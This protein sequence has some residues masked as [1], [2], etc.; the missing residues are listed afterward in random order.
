MKFLYWLFLV[1]LVIGG[2]N[3]A[4]IGWF[5]INLVTKIF[6]DVMKTVMTNGVETTTTTLNQLAMITY[7]V[8]GVSALWVFIANLCHKCSK[9]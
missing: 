5:D 8:V 9:K 2:L 7:T 4:L 3:R 1:I 6:P